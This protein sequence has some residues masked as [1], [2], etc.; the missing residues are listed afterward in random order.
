M[1]HAGRGGAVQYAES[2]SNASPIRQAA[3]GDAEKPPSQIGSWRSG[4]EEGRGAG[5]ERDVAEGRRFRAEWNDFLPDLH[6]G[7]EEVISAG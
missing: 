2:T 7:A 3:Y 1:A 4:V 6:R 5:A